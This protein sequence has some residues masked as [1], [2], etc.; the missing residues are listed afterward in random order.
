VSEND[1]EIAPDPSGRGWQ[2]KYNPKPERDGRADATDHEPLPDLVDWPEAMHASAYY[3]LPGE[4][5]MVRAKHTEADPA[6]ILVQ[7]QIMFGNDVG[8]KP[9]IRVGSAH[10]HTNEYAI[11]PGPTSAGRKQT[12]TVEAREPFRVADPEWFQNNLTSG[13][14]TDVGL[15]HALRDDLITSEAVKDKKTGR[16]IGYQDVITA[17]VKDK[18][19]CVVE[20]EFSV[21]IIRS[22]REGNG[23]SGLLRQGYDH[24][25]LRNMSKSSF[26]TVTGP[27]ISII[28]HITSDEF[29]YVVSDIDIA[30]GFINRFL[31]I[32]VKRTQLL[33]F[34]G[35][36]DSVEMERLT[37]RLRD[38]IAWA[39]DVERVRWTREAMDLWEVE[40]PRLTAPRLGPAGRA[41]S[42]AEVHALRLAMLYALMDKSDRI[43]PEHLR[44]ALEVVAY[45]ERSARFIFADRLDNRHAERV[46]SVLRQSPTPLARSQIR[47]VAFG[48]NIS[49][50]K[51]AASLALLLKH[52]LVVRSR[53]EAGAR[54][55]RPE[56]WS[57][58]GREDG[59]H[60]ESNT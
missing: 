58:A 8:P 39:R 14:S 55:R 53:P 10:H 38:A 17:G 25:K 6:A 26:Y 21:V 27:H 43:R 31:I 40:Y 45:S 54:G 52:G 49:A 11:F 28:A 2:W 3:G 18:R 57:I 23:L 46:L 59:D 41:C 60:D 44:A 30:N 48:D 7:T 16:V 47:R 56:L 19:L 29:I 9:Y 32:C 4:L 50:D 20:P 37:N 5:A 12:S 1:V 13:L 24:E 22:N 35:K 36:P 42:R 33:P 34:G 51:V 15:L